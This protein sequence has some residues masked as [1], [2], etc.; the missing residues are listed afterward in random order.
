M[1]LVV[2]LEV[3]AGVE[4]LR[5][6]MEPLSIAAPKAVKVIQQIFYT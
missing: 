5:L 3:A 6:G 1:H 4:P 2:C